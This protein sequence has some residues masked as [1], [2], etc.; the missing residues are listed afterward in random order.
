[1]AY[2]KAGMKR[3]ARDLYADMLVNAVDPDMKARVIALSTELDGSADAAMKQI[4]EKRAL[5]AK[6]APNFTL[7]NYDGQPVSLADYRGKVVMLNF[8]HPT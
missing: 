5:Q 2:D 7:K 1:M 6:D 3:E 8:W 4:Q